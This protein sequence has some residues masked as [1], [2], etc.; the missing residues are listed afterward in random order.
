MREFASIL[1]KGVALALLLL[2]ASRPAL[3]Q[4]KPGE[5]TVYVSKNDGKANTADF[6]V[7]NYTRQAITC[8]SQNWT[9]P[10]P[11]SGAIQPWGVIAST[12]VDL[13][14]KASG[15][16]LSFQVG[17]GASATTIYV[18]NNTLDHQDGVWWQLGGDSSWTIQGVTVNPPPYVDPATGACTYTGDFS[19][20]GF[21]GSYTAVL[22]RAIW[23]D[24]ENEKGKSKVVLLIGEN[25]PGSTGKAYQNCSLFP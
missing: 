1:A 12:D 8:S 20:G 21:S 9:L 18:Q 13:S 3:G 14:H 11:F 15:G 5:I 23:G 24:K 10:N 17:S 6:Y 7:V 4:N 16:R 19:A 25:V 22:T 2:A